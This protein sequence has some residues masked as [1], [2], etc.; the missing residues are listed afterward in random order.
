MVYLPLKWELLRTA[1]A[2]RSA[3]KYLDKHSN[4][5]NGRLLF[6]LTLTFQSVIWLYL[7][8]YS[9]YAIV[10]FLMTLYVHVLMF[11]VRITEAGQ[12]KTK[13]FFKSLK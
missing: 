13:V 7:L 8:D 10:A 11:L 3:L 1:K 6:Y 12:M 2:K 5:Y 9:M 4:C